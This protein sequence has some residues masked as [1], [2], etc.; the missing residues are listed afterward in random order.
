MRSIV[1]TRV[2]VTVWILVLAAAHAVEQQKSS[3]SNRS[4][5]RTRAVGRA[6]NQ[7]DDTAI[8]NTEQQQQQLSQALDVLASLGVEPCRWMES[9]DIIFQVSK[10]QQGETNGNLKTMT[11]TLLQLPMCLSTVPLVDTVESIDRNT[12]FLPEEES[13]T[14]TASENR[15]TE[16]ETDN[17]SANDGNTNEEGGGDN[18]ETE[19]EEESPDTI[20]MN[21]VGATV[22]VC[23][24]ALAAGLT[25][26]MLGLDPLM[27][28][29]KER[30]SDNPTERTQARQLL[31]LVKQHHR[32]LVTLLLMNS[33]ANEALPIFLEAL[34]PPSVAILVSVTLVLFFGEIIPSAVFTGPNQLRIASALVPVVR[35]AMALLS[36]LAWP[37]AKLLDCL[38]HSDEEGEESSAV[39]KRGELSALIR[40]QY[41]E[42]LAAKRK[43]K[44][45]RQ[46]HK[47]SLKLLQGET[48]GALDFSV[49]PAAAQEALNNIK[50]IK[51]HMQHTESMRSER[52]SFSNTGSIR[53]PAYEGGPMQRSDSLHGDEVIMIEGALQ[54][55]TNVAL[56][57][58][59]PLRRMFAVPDTLR[60]SDRAMVQIYASGFSRVPVYCVQPDKPKSKTAIVG[61]L[62]TKQLIV[63]DPKDARPVTSMP[64]YT[65]FC[66]SPQTPLVELVNLFQTGRTR[67]LKGGHLALVCARPREGNIALD[68]GDALPNEA[69][70]MGIITLE[71]VLESLLQEQIYDEN[72]VSLDLGESLGNESILTHVLI[73]AF[74]FML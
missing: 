46:Q 7:S 25:L 8:F 51:S 9:N 32:L 20:L 62:M 64:L 24:A 22:C 41:E 61:V 15:P 45:E 38:L 73:H 27:L 59:T 19:E 39:Y 55:K 44:K 52:S 47:H 16:P 10:Q 1:T 74:N 23:V 42:R 69:G 2:V 17:A 28:L 58:Y 5:I 53:P 6:P 3:S 66:V 65:P 63:L 21:F 33:I 60:L 12:R 30:A 71:D 48:V 43:R 26:G 35:L 11:S 50:A 54:M 37:I 4:S 49:P 56:D 13:E 72:D 70:L 29:I 18:Q 34:V 14:A 57:V 68:R 67:A 40:I 36:P 31:P